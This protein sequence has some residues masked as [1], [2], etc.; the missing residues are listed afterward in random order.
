MHKKYIFYTRKK[1]IKEICV[2]TLTKISDRLPE[3]LFFI[4]PDSILFYLCLHRPLIPPEFVN[5]NSFVISEERGGSVVE[6][7][8]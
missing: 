6:C 8:A 3:I 2:S 5:E 1:V 4:W 7:L